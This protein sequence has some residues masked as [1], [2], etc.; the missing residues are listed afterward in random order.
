MFESPL[1]A[2]NG[3]SQTSLLDIFCTEIVIWTLCGQCKNCYFLASDVSDPEFIYTRPD[4]WI[5]C[6]AL[7]KEPH[8]LFSPSLNYT[9]NLRPLSSME[10]QFPQ[11]S[12]FLLSIQYILAVSLPYFSLFFRNNVFQLS[13]L[14]TDEDTVK[15]YYAKFEEK[16]FQT[17]EKELAKINTFYSGNHV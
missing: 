5:W 17:C 8:C 12:F 13:C 4:M 14:V 2:Y 3:L 11:V 6:A 16:F 15:R 1:N 10:E 7:Q 9:H